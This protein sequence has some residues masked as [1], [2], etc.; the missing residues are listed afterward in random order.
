MGNPYPKRN[1]RV[2]ILYW[3]S[4]AIQDLRIDTLVERLKSTLRHYYQFNVTVRELKQDE[5]EFQNNQLSLADAILNETGKMPKR[6]LLKTADG[7]EA[8]TSCSNMAKDEDD[9]LMLLYIGR[10]THDEES[11]CLLQPM[12][13]QD[14]G[15][16]VQVD[17]EALRRATLNRLHPEVL[18]VLDC[19]YH[20]PIRHKDRVEIITSSEQTE[21]F[22]LMETLGD[23]FDSGSWAMQQRG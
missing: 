5:D 22:Q 3:D 12:Q 7:E 15:N 23:V 1:V 21:D 14:L 6:R 19:P 16:K 4:D 20:G 13:D 9:L 10:S 2:L 18:M 17:F 8:R 11:K